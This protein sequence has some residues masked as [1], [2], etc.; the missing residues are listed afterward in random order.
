MHFYYDYTI[1]TFI[2]GSCVLFDLLMHQNDNYE[3]SANTQVTNEAVPQSN[4]V[5]ALSLSNVGI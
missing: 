4:E 3:S 5:A 2:A 1:Q